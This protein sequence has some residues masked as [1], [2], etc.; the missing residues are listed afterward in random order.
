MLSKVFCKRLTGLSLVALFY[1]NIQYHLYFFVRFFIFE[2]AFSGQFHTL[3]ALIWCAIGL[4]LSGRLS[5]LYTM[6]AFNSPGTNK[7]LKS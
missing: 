7:E 5:A 1:I 2:F 6:C 3:I 4:T